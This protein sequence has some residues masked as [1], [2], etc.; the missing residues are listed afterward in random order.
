MLVLGRGTWPDLSRMCLLKDDHRL[1]ASANLEN[2]ESSRRS[3]AEINLY[4][5]CM[6]KARRKGHDVAESCAREPPKI[7]DFALLSRL[8]QDV[9]TIRIHLFDL[10]LI[11]RSNARSWLTIRR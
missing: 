6:D 10:V 5:S 8:N 7:K 1:F 11:L 4:L 2:P 3:A 9:C